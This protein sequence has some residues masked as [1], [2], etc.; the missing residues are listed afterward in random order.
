MYSTEVP[1]LWT[2][3]IETHRQHVRAAIIEAT[4]RLVAERGLAAVNMSHVAEAAGIGR[5]TLYK[6]FPDVQS[7][8][9]AWHADQIATHLLHLTALV[10][11][12]DEPAVALRSVMLAYAHICA[13]RGGHEPELNA[14]LHRGSGDVAQA[15]VRLTELFVE[16]IDRSAQA[17][18]LRT[19]IPST[20]LAAF[21]IHALAAADTLS[22]TDALERL[23]DLV[24]AGLCPPD[25]RA[26]R[27]AVPRPTT[28]GHRSRSSSGR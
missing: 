11:E 4:A 23:V 2:D 22:T 16:L 19:D 24:L 5:A 27:A 25:D 13:H 6:Y 17:G 14:L 8:I 9:T 15:Q 21:C 10:D 3:T 1:R 28:K 12:N 7:I 18:A 20:E 26:R